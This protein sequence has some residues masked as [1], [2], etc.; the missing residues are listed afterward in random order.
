MTERVTATTARVYGSMSR[1]GEP[2]QAP[3]PPM[4]ILRFPTRDHTV[5]VTFGSRPDWLFDADRTGLAIGTAAR[6]LVF[7]GLPTGMSFAER[8]A[9]A[10]TQLEQIPEKHHFR[11]PDVRRRCPGG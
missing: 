1:Y 4:Q 5:E 6:D 10:R 9:L 7:G 11:I 3:T 2:Y 8:V